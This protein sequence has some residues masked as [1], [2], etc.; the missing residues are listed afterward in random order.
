VGHQL[1]HGSGRG[2][3]DDRAGH[4]VPVALGLKPVQGG[5]GGLGAVQGREDTNT[6]ASAVSR[7]PRIAECVSPVPQS[8][9]MR[10]LKLSR[11]ATAARS[12]VSENASAVCG[13]RAEASAV[14]AV[15]QQEDF[16][17]CTDA[18]ARATDEQAEVLARYHGGRMA[19]EEAKDPEYTGPGE[20]GTGFYL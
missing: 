18:V 17:A 14:G 5:G 10:F 8:V 3:D 19:F 9:R 13:S 16:G 11:I 6:R 20:A 15:T 2:D 4:Q 1:V 7:T 12:S